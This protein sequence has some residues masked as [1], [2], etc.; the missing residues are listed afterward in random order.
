M[1]R[2]CPGVVAMHG[3]PG[4]PCA[5]AQA[6]WGCP[7]WGKLLSPTLDV[8]TA[9]KLLSPLLVPVQGV[10]PKRRRCRCHLRQAQGDQPRAGCKRPEELVSPIT[11]SSVPAT[12]GGS[13]DRDVSSR[14][15]PLAALGAEELVLLRETA[16][17]LS[18]LF[19]RV[20]WK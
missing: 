18:C 20:S 2:G 1:F 3:G 17:P 10:S 4:S 9:P 8:G 15:S 7:E 6:S 5:P 13:G 16:S 19:T 12:D 11:T 14:V